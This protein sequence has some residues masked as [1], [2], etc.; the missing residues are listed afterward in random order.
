VAIGTIVWLYALA[1]G[2]SAIIAVVL[3]I[4]AA[5]NMK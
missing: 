2:I 4:Y 5:R 1:F 3:L